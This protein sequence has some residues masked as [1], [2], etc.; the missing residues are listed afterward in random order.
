MNK[1]EIAPNKHLGIIFQ[2]RSGSHV[3]RQYLS[4]LTNRL[5]LGEWYNVYIDQ[6]SDKLNI[7]DN[8]AYFNNNYSIISRFPES[9]IEEKSRLIS[10]I[11]K[12]R[13][14]YDIQRY[15]VATIQ[16]SGFVENE[17]GEMLELIAQ[18]K[19]TQY[20]FLDRADVLYSIISLRLSTHKTEFHN[21]SDVAKVRNYEP[22]QL[23]VKILNK[24][25]ETYIRNKDIVHKY[26]GD[27]PIIY[28]E[29][30]QHRVSN[31]LNLF[32]GIP[33]RMIGVGMNKWQGNHKEMISNIDE[34]EDYYEEFV[35][36]HPEYF[37][38]YF[39]KLP[40]ITIPASQ[41][42]QPRIL[43]PEYS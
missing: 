39:G 31:I 21:P 16:T 18:E 13:N 4:E 22:L 26:F 42:R 19:N 34:V 6:Q 3:L 32:T 30:Y 9:G 10:N 2:P 24:S 17:W 27:I 7:T 36:K 43:L 5:D 14:L 38:Q 1:I 23:P 28:Y 11:E 37:P 8:T 15:G 25:L 20:I 12:M 33:K 29:Q 40:H 35:N 41:G